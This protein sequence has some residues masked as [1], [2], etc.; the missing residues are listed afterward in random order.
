MAH[1]GA[2]LEHEHVEPGLGEHGRR[3]RTAGAGANDRDIAVLAVASRPEVAEGRCLR[4]GLALADG[5]A[6]LVAH[7]GDGARVARPA[8]HRQ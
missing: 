2:G 1:V 5:A 3:D 8:D 7:R 4:G 6:R